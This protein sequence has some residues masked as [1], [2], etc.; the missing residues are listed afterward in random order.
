MTENKSNNKEK[1]DGRWLQN[2]SVCLS[3][4]PLSPTGTN[5][6]QGLRIAVTAAVTI[7]HA[8]SP[9]YGM[10]DRYRPS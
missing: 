5:L 6:S 7:M 8:S 2:L 10:D 4:W 3:V 1:N 9:S